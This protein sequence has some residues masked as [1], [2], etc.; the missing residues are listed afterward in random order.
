[1]HSINVLLFFHLLSSPT[2]TSAQIAR[3]LT[4]PQL[5]D[6]PI[7]IIELTCSEDPSIQIIPQDQE[8]K[9][10]LALNKEVY[11][12]DPEKKSQGHS[13]SRITW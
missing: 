8:V 1:M 3:V 6:T 10:I 5:D 13:T 2:N 7:G 12:A 9:S 4:H 11:T